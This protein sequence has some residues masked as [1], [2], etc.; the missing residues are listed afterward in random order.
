MPDLLRWGIT[1]LDDGSV[2][3]TELEVSADEEKG[4]ITLTMGEG[5]LRYFRTQKNVAEAR[6]VRGAVSM[7]LLCLLVRP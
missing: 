2:T 7:E 1:D 4:S 5:F 3:A 6:L